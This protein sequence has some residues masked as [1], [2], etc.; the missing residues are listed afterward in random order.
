MSNFS[1]TLKIRGDLIIV[2]TD[3]DGNTETYHHKNLV[4][5]TGKDYI[6]SRMSS[7]TANIMS[8]MAVGTGS[9]AA[10]VGQTLLVTEIARVPLTS[11]TVTSNSITY[12]ASYPA[13]TATG[14]LQEAGI[15]NGGT[16]AAN[17]MLCRTVFSSVAK[18]AA[19]SIT[20][21][22]VVSIT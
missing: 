5:N 10:A 16:T 2:K 18:G 12:V 15:F 13:G 21:T 22:W 7:N 1:D 17:T 9:T 14:T 19:D 4:V 20:I 3:G 8:H 11:Q 6:A